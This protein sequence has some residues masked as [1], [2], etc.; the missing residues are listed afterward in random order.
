VSVGRHHEYRLVMRASAETCN[1]RPYVR[2]CPPSGGSD[3]GSVSVFRY[4]AA[5]VL[6]LLVPLERSLE[7]L[8]NRV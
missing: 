4:E 7:E 8:S 6:A 1:K 2:H 5:K 3:T